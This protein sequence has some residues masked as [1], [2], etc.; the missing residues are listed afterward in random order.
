MSNILIAYYSRKGENYW[1][2]EIRALPQGNT[3]IVAEK[4]QEITQG[5]L[6]EIDTVDSYPINYRECTQV[7]MD[8]FKSKARPLLKSYPG[9]LCNYDT[10]FIGYP[11]W[12]GTAPM[13]VFS[14][15]ENY[16]LTGKKLI[17]F[18]TNEGSGMGNSEKDIA[19]TAK[20]AIIAK[21][22]ALVGHKVADADNEIK[23]WI[24]KVI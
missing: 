9:K 15:L 11:N 6:F 16:D 10:I 5:E 24:K 22:L 20:G 7:A 14:F 13:A 2:G 21:G 23:A 1:N 12:W 3:E 17:P 8:E 19:V 4:I 18:C